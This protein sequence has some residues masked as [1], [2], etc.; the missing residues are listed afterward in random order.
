[1]GLTVCGVRPQD[2]D[3]TFHRAFDK[4]RRPQEALEEL[5]SCGVPRVLTSGSAQTAL[6]VELWTGP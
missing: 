1:M 5:V 2:L 6:Q 4:V 3:F